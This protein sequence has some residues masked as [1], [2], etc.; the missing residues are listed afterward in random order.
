MKHIYVLVIGLLILSGCS[1]TTNKVPLPEGVMPEQIGRFRITQP[2]EFKPYSNFGEKGIY[3]AVYKLGNETSGVDYSLYL[4]S[5]SDE[6]KKGFNEINGSNKRTAQFKFLQETDSK[7]AGTMQGTETINVL[8]LLGDKIASFSSGG[9]SAEEFENNFPYNAFGVIK[10]SQQASYKSDIK[11]V[12]SLID[13]Y[14]KSPKETTEMYHQKEILFSG[15]VDEA[16][17]TKKGDAGI[18]FKRPNAK[19]YLFPDVMA[20]SFKKEE[21]EKVQALKKGQ[22]VKFRCQVTMAVGTV[23]LHNCSLL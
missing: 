2:P 6:A 10:P 7:S 1:S 20:T 13:D 11:P 19:T 22:E 4:Y 5:S 3:K 14:Q 15:T 17:T 9:T 23:V 18:I 16:A 21:T 12:L 8:L